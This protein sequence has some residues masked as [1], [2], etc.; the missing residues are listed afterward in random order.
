[1]SSSTVAS[2]SPQVSSSRRTYPPAP[3]A[4]GPIRAERLG[5]T[6]YCRT[7]L[8]S[9]AV[10]L[11]FLPCSCHPPP[12]PYS[13]IL[14][15]ASPRAYTASTYLQQCPT[16]S[17]RLIAPPIV[18][19]ICFLCVLLTAP[20]LFS[21]CRPVRSASILLPLRFR[22]SGTPSCACRNADA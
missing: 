3:C 15:A 10:L 12:S 7:G 6:H 16:S 8:H 11:F 20:L 9:C 17:V 18:L 14:H 13:Y 22:L 1:M 5:S 2:W 19:A 4:R 21:S